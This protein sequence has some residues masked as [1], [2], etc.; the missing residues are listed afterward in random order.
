M[1]LLLNTKFFVMKVSS[2]TLLTIALGAAAGA[3]IAYLLLSDDG[4]EILGN[5]KNKAGDLTGDFGNEA[6]N[7]GKNIVG[8]LLNTFA[9]V[10]QKA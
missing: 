10:S 4:R 2:T 3:G 6:G 7:A 1:E 9:S 5:L 8:A